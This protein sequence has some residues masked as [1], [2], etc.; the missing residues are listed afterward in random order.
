MVDGRHH[1]WTLLRMHCL[2][3]PATSQKHTLRVS[4]PP[5]VP[6]CTRWHQCHQRHRKCPKLPFKEPTMC[7]SA[8]QFTFPTWKKTRH[9][10]RQAK[11]KKRQLCSSLKP[12][13]IN[14]K[15]QLP[16]HLSSIYMCN[17]VSQ[18]QGHNCLIKSSNFHYHVKQCSDEWATLAD[19]ESWK[20]QVAP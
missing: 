16:T 14:P 6:L 1:R 4:F 10:A 5:V 12:V 11:K 19:A 15:A 13:K 9:Q 7:S 3:I 8:G 17:P 20:W 18:S 2:H